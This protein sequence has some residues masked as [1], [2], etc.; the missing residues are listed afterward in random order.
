MGARRAQIVYYLCRNGQLEHPHFMELS[1]L[2][3]QQLRLKDVMER[4][5]VLRGKGMPSLYSWSCK[6]SYKNGY[7]WNDLSENDVIYPADGAEYVLKGSEIVPGC[8]EQYQQLRLRNNRPTKTLPT[9]IQIEPEPEDYSE[10]TEEEEEEE[11]P[12]AEYRKSRNL[13]E[14]NDT[15]SRTRCSR[16]VST[17]QLT[18]R[19][20]GGPHQQTEIA[21]DD[22]S[23]PSSSSSDRAV[24]PSG[25]T[26][27][28]VFFNLIACGSGVGVK[29]RKSGGNLH[30]GVVTS[31]A[32]RASRVEDVEEVRFMSENPR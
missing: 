17:E 14:K 31:R 18:Q 19:K 22:G 28:S 2:P 32:A 9:R 21:L 5:T 16:G 27:N 1:Q 3:N 4:L 26:K 25:L 7:V 20:P 15:H 29:G 6:R 23:P 30:K 12:E 10:E 11:E 13:T 24:E 8:S